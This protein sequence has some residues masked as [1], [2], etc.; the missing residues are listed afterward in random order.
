MGA[1]E[2]Q[3]QARLIVRLERSQHRKFPERIGGT[4]REQQIAE[5]SR[6]LEMS[7]SMRSISDQ[8]ASAA[9]QASASSGATT[10]TSNGEP[11]LARP[12]LTVT[13]AAGAAA[14]TTARVTAR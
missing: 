7:A 11:I 1:R 13:A 6:Q 5:L 8:A 12:L 4:G 9:R 10:V 2:S 14:A 3:V